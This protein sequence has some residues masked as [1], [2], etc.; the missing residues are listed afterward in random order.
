MGDQH[1]IYSHIPCQNQ[2]FPGSV[3]PNTTEQQQ[4]S[5]AS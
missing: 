5:T 3:N 1:D 2:R 4:H